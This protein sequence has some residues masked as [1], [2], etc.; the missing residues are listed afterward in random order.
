[1]NEKFGTF[2]SKAQRYHQ[3]RPKYSIEY[4]KY[5]EMSQRGRSPAVVA[6]IGAGTGIHTRILAPFFKKIYAIEPEIEML[7]I[8]KET[9]S[10]LNN[11]D[12]ILSSAEKTNLPDSSIDFITI[13]EAFHLLD[14]SLCIPEFKRVLKKDGQVILVWLHKEYETPLFRER[15]EI[16]KSHCPCYQK[17]VHARKLLKDTFKELFHSESFSYTKLD[18]DS[19]EYLSKEIFVYRTLSASYAITESDCGYCSLIFDLE[20]L[21]DK[22]AK[23]NSLEILQSTI[24]YQGNLI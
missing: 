21:F 3:Y 22:Y 24:I 9:L 23:G 7:S 16:I 15:E 1:M 17:D 5:I 14:K 20:N 11:V 8:C 12:Y 19:N 6:D 18:F 13:G 10:D 4:Q 2:A